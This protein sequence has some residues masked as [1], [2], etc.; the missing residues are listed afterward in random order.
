[1]LP[2]KVTKIGTGLSAKNYLLYYFQIKPKWPIQRLQSLQ[3]IYQFSGFYFIF[4]KLKRFKRFCGK[5]QFRH[6]L[7]RFTRNYAETVP[8]HKI[9]TPR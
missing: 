7:G 3:E 5:A 8:S 1:M 4:E 2:K 6:S 9:S